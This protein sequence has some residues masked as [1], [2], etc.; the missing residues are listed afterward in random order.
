MGATHMDSIWDILACPYCTHVLHHEREGATCTQCGERY[1]LTDTG[2]L[3]MR[4]KRIKTCPLEF[5]VGDSV[6]HGRFRFDPLVENEAPEVNFSGI[7]VP[8]H[9][10][11]ELISYFPQAKTSNSLVLDLGCGNTIHKGVCEHAGFK[12]VG[13]DYSSPKAP[14]LGDAHAL[15]FLDGSFE[16][17]LSIAVLEHIRFPFVMM[18]EAHRVLKPG[19]KFIGTVAFLEPFHGDSFYHHTHL[20]ALNSLLFG[21]FWVEHIAPSK[22]WSVLTA[23]AS[24]ALFPKMPKA[25]SKSLVMPLNV[26]HKLWW[27]VAKTMGKADETTRIYKTTGA[28][29]FIAWKG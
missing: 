8:H 29:S 24:M 11:K 27:R 25:L 17:I 1:T 19:G 6:P 18:H 22:D 14:V 13:L 28:V 9:L 2:A 10:T 4:L 26:M 21:G 16:F 23:Q 20:G 15:P 7:A 12:Y 3:D 5:Q